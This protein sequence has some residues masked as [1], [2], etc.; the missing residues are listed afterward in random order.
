MS[1]KRLNVIGISAN[2]LPPD[3]D[4]DVFRGKELQYAES[5]MVKYV[6][7]AGAA[8]ILIPDQTS[9]EAATEVLSRI[10]GLLLAGGADV[11][12]ESYGQTE[13]DERWPGDKRRDDYEKMLINICLDMGKPLLGICRGLQMINVYF[14]GTLWQDNNEFGP[15]EKVHRDSKVYDHLHHDVDIHADTELAKVYAPGRHRINSIHHQS[16][17]DLG[18]GLKVSAV[19]EDGLVEG[20][21]RF[22]KGWVMGVQWHP[23]WIDE[24][25]DGLLHADPLMERFLQEVRVKGG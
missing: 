9:R 14:G 25:F 17:R 7:R 10:D 18:P 22:D 5:S 15:T 4:R 2:F 8:P 19:S 23:E 6:A 13:Y 16:I 12:P 20:V 24:R 21:E 1:A 3:P 11:C